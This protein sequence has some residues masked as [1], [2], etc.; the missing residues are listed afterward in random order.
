MAPKKNKSTPSRNSLHSGTSSSNPTPSSVWFRD[1][2]ALQDFLEN[3]SRRGNHSKRQVVLSDFSDTD[4]L[5]VIYSRGWESLCDIPITFPSVIIQK[6]YSNMHGF[7]YFVPH[8]STRIRGKRIVVTPDL[9][10]AVIHFPRVAHPDYPGCHCLKTV[11]KDKLMSLFCEMPSSWGEHQNTP[12][13][14]FAKGP[15]FLNMVMT[16]AFHTLSHYNSITEPYA[17]FL[18][19]LFE[20]LTIDFPSHFILSFIDVYKDIVTRDKLIFPSAITWILRHASVSYPESPHFSVMCAINAAT[21]RWRE[22]PLRPKWPQTEIATPPASSTPSTSA[23]SSSVDG[24]TLEAIM[25]QFR[26][27]DACFDTLI[28]EIY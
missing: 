3:F 12:Y 17:R 23:P 9:I 5:I 28:T 27:M 8:F 16:F 7:D 18:L 4:L 14:A 13:S 1:D 10:S 19:S 22:A 20:R 26:R 2:K 21:V 15:R 24:V 25:A 6:F 11:F